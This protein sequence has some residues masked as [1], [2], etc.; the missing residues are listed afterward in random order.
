MKVKDRKKKK[1][2]KIDVYI[3]IM[4]IFVLA[5]ILWCSWEFHVGRDEPTALIGLVGAYVVT[6]LFSLAKIKAKKEEAK[7]DEPVG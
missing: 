6:E 2:N 1:I 3:I 4:S 5:F 7:N